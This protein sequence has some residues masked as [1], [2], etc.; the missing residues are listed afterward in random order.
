MAGIS[1]TCFGASGETEVLIG[2]SLNVIGH[3]RA[4]RSEM[5]GTRAGHDEFI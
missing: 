2:V 3:A 4:Y 1:G 5:A